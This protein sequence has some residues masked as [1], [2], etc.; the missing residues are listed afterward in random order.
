M[1]MEGLLTLTL[2]T[3]DN[4]QGSLDIDVQK[5]EKKLSIKIWINMIQ[6]YLIMI[7]RQ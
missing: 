4:Q 5:E 7:A 1:L 2:L 3:A 6:L